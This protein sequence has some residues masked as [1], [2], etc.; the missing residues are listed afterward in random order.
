KRGWTMTL[1]WK[2][3]SDTIVA[4]A[5]VQ[6]K[7]LMDFIVRAFTKVGVPAA[8]ADTVA[9]LMVEADLRGGDTHG[10]IRLPLYVRRIRAGGVNPKPDIRVVN[11]RPSA[12]LIDGG[13]GM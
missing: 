2:K 5:R 3:M 6:A 12:A 1:R 4:P 13:N 11:E 7:P 10:V 9:Q 8:D